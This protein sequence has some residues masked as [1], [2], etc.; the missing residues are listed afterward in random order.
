MCEHIY[1]EGH[2]IAASV[3]RPCV[4]V[5]WYIHSQLFRGYH[6]S[7]TIDS[8]HAGPYRLQY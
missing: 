6:Y 8:V 7:F 2:V 4:P 5:W 3:S 1:D